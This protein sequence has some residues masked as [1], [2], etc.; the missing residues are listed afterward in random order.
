MF[1]GESDPAHVGTSWVD[2]GFAW[3]QADPCPVCVPELAE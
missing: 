1:P 3:S 2:P